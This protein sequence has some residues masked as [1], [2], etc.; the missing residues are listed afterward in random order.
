MVIRA[1]LAF[2]PVT[3]SHAEKLVRG[4]EKTL[5]GSS[6]TRVS[7]PCFC[8][9]SRSSC[10][11]QLPSAFLSFYTCF[12]KSAHN[13]HAWIDALRRGWR[14][15]QTAEKKMVKM[16]KTSFK[17]QGMVPLVVQVVGSNERGKGDDF[18][19]FINFPSRYQFPFSP[20]WPGKIF[21][22]RVWNVAK[23]WNSNV[24]FI[25]YTRSFPTRQISTFLKASWRREKFSAGE[26]Y[27]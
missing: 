19:C 6:L 24:G 18:K 12:K 1:M 14:E 7:G 23:Y 17:P 16:W 27:A 20:S 2:S 4:R 21:F 8:A 26:Y 11:S 13:F 5:N 22:Q 15:Y 10:S 9:K 25:F 3:R